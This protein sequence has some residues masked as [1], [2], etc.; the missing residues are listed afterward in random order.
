MAGSMFAPGKTLKKV[1]AVPT[2]LLHARFGGV[3]S[4][5]DPSFQVLKIVAEAGSLGLHPR[6]CTLGCAESGVGGV[7]RGDRR[8]YVILLLCGKFLE[9]LA[10]LPQRF[11]FHGVHRGHKFLLVI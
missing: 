6:L 7:G 2:Q 11:T 5:A 4:R 8:K 1:L 3:V 10:E 9:R